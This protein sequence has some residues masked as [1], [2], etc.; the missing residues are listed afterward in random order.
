MN[1]NIETTENNANVKTSTGADLKNHVR[2]IL[3][4]GNSSRSKAVVTNSVVT[5][6][7]MRP[8]YNQN[9]VTEAIKKFQQ[10]PLMINACNFK[11][12]TLEVING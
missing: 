2:N 7:D 3:N 9:G 6:N 1:N 4:K 11:P 10:E 8:Y 5:K 12:N